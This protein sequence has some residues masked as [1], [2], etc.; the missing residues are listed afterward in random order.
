MN[1]DLSTLS[2]NEL[3]VLRTNIDTALAQA[4]ARDRQAA[5]DAAK[6]AASEFGFS[7][8]ELSNA[9]PNKRR[10]MRANGSL[11]APRYANPDNPEMTWTGKGRKPNWFTEALS[12][13]TNPSEM[14][15]S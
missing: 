1:I 4:E 10:G 14:E 7:L 6:A 3:K 8:D 11:S 9:N 12:R 5:L 13:G 2:R 15:I